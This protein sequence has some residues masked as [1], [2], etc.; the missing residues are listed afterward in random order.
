MC[1]ET[2][3]ETINVC[4][5]VGNEKVTKIIEGEVVLQDIKPD[6]LSIVKV[7][8]EIC[9]SKKVIED[10][11]IRVDGIIDV[12][13]VYIADDETNS[14]RGMNSS[15]N[16]S[17]VIDFNGVNPDS[18]IKFKYD[19]GAI[20]YK[21]INGRKISIKCNLNFDVKAFNNC[22]I[23]IIKGIMNDDDMQLQKINRNICSPIARNVNHVDINENVKLNDNNSPISEILSYNIM[24]SNKEYK[25]SYNK[26]LAKAEA[27]IKIIYIADNET[28][29]I[30]TFETTLPVMG[31][32]DVDGINENDDVS[33]DYEIKNFSVRPFYQDMQSNAISVDGV[34]DVIVFSNE[35]QDIDL[36]TDFYTPN[37]NI[38]TE[39]ENVNVLKKLIDREETIEL[40]QAL[41]VPDLED[42][43]IL[44]IDGI[45]KIN[46]RN[47]LNGKLAITGNIDVNL[48]YSKKDSHIVENKKL[49]LPF[50]QVV[51]FEELT[52]EM[53]PIIHIK[54]DDIKYRIS[55]E[56]QIQVE[57]TIIVNLIADEEVEINSI[58]KLDIS[59]EKL[60]L[61]PS[62][63]IYYVKAGDS[64]WSIAKRFR[65][66]IDYIKEINELKDDVIY[67]GQRLLI[68]RLQA[69]DTVNSLM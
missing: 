58:T 4:K 14:V 62:I 29:N 46:E 30:E 49:D 56:N 47:V 40:N 6:I 5:Y 41:V 57:I 51:K 52:N 67:P 8:R 2:I 45:L 39:T 21:V 61:M 10:N 42:T 7:S 64:L 66:T 24:L 12:C 18:I 37:S 69:K 50:Q 16:F 20:E 33:I 19:A 36:V 1:A 38:K 32:I 55:G 48:F 23:N 15:I 22:E 35:N 26:V 17:E 28:Q 11:R 68:P 27:K 65:N 59:D 44:S 60:P 25:L 54:I 9:I 13:I 31:F 34:I 63:V 3:N 43:N 53:N